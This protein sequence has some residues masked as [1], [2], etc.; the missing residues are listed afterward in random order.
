MS[1]LALGSGRMTRRDEVRIGCSGWNYNH[2]RGLFYPEEQRPQEWF[3][4]YARFFDTVEINNTF[5]RLPAEKTFREWRAQAPDGFIYA[6]KAS[7][8]L[9]HMK[10]LKEAEKP[11][12]TFLQRASLLKEHFGPVLYQLPPH[13]GLNRE[14][15]ESFLELLPADLLHVFEFRDQSWLVDEVFDLLERRGAS[16][17]VHDFP[18]LSVPKIAMGPIAYVR[19][20]GAQGTYQGSYTDQQLR[21]WWGWMEKELRGGRGLYVYFNND[22]EASAVRDALRLKK[23]AGID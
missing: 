19:F 10:K 7:R 6:V 16:L 4:T 2:W 22:A 1:A 5:Y 17:C 8:Y 15:L 21:S 9:T 13:W 23:R 14:R 11:L 18:G 20:H 12:K 3:A